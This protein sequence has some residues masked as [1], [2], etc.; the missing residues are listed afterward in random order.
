MGL[1]LLQPPAYDPRYG[2]AIRYATLGVQ[3]AQQ[4]VMA[5]DDPHW[6]VGLLERDNWDGQTA[7]Q[8]HIRSNC[9]ARQVDNYLRPNV[10][11]TTQLITDSAAINV[12]F[13]AYLTWLGFQEPNNDFT[14]LTK[15]TLPD[16][17]Y[18]NTAL[19]FLAYA[20]EHCSLEEARP[21]DEQ[22]TPEGYLYSARQ[23]H[24]W[25]RLLVNGPL[26]NS[27]EFASEF[28]CPI[29]SPMNPASKCIIY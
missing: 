27:V 12:A 18:S 26:R 20:Q 15:E 7:W 25:T 29:G 23:N 21:R 24:T 8:Y 16:L 1:A 19:F 10:S 5:F 13:R 9:F 2:H 11:A 28:R 17:N 6:S 4:L 14:K 3:L 22:G